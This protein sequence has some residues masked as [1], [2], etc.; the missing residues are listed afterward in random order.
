MFSGAYSHVNLFQ[1]CTVLQTKHTYIQGYTNLY[2]PP[3]LSI[4]MES[5]GFYIF[6]T[7]LERYSSHL[8]SEV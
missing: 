3:T 7:K 5:M 4:Q 6:P 8:P 2:P 1:Q